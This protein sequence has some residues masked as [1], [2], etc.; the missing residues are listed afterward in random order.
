MA[1]G[2]AGDAA[3]DAADGLVEVIVLLVGIDLRLGPDVAEE[4]GG[5]DVV[6][7]VLDESLAAVCGSLVVHL[8]VWGVARRVRLAL[9]LVDDV[10]HALGQEAVEEGSQH[11]H[12]EVPARDAPAQALGHLLEGA[13]ELRP[14][15]C[16][17]LWHAKSPVE[18]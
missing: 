13:M 3:E 10:L 15:C 12:L 6:A 8:G 9:P 7:D 4:V 5:G 1:L 17:V 14:L 16:P 11:V 2:R 18:R